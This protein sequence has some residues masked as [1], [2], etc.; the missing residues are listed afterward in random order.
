[1]PRDS[2]SVFASCRYSH[3]YN[4]SRFPTSVSHCASNSVGKSNG[5][6]EKSLTFCCKSAN[7]RSDPGTSAFAPVYFPN[8]R[9][10]TKIGRS[11]S[12][13]LANCSRKSLA[14]N[15]VLRRCCASSSNVMLLLPPPL[16]FPNILNPP[17]A[18]SKRFSATNTGRARR[19]RRA[20]ISLTSPPISL[21]FSHRGQDPDQPKTRYWH[22]FGRRRS[23]A[24][25]L[26]RFRTI[27]P[28]LSLPGRPPQRKPQDPIR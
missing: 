20:E 27:G 18:N 11:V 2:F 10:G 14:I 17:L 24:P 28:P 9:S 16:I 1:M 26:L 6:F 3:G 25:I 5:C 22:P 4:S 12:K 19:P 8:T 7:T 21:A 15:S 13:Y 23:F